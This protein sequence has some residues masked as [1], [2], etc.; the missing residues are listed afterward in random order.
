M[1]SVKEETSPQ[2]KAPPVK[3][4]AKKSRI[5]AHVANIGR[6]MI[7]ELRSIRSDP[8]M[9]ILVVYAFSIAI[10]TVANGASTEAT[11]LAV[12]IVDE[13]HSALSRKI[14]DGLTPPLF[15]R[16]VEI[17]PSDIDPSMD[18]NRFVFVIEIPPDFQADVLA[19]R[20]TSV[21][22]NADAT[23]ITQAGNGAGYIQTII[24]NEVA[25]SLTGREAGYP[26]PVNAVVRV[27]FNPNLHSS[28]FTSVMQVINN[29][30]MLTVILSGAAL[31][32][33]REQG[34]VEHLLVMPVVPAEI[35]L[36]KMLANG[37]VTLVAA[38]LSL[39]FVVEW[40]LKVPIVG[41]IALFIGGSFF[42]VFTVAA[43]GILL[44]TIAASMGQF[45]LLVIPVLLV[46]MLLS[47]SMTPMES[48]PDWLQYI[49]QIISPTPHFVAFAQGV[50]YRG[51]GLSIVWPQLIAIIIIGSVYF[52]FALRR[53]RRVIFGA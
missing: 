43:L 19:G 9:L 37:L 33:E 46:M 16:A 47:G 29:V 11:N 21:Q 8:V 45:G 32:R 35:M 2:S 40:W 49:M 38:A 18:S 6:L 20:Q 48:M 28:W 52:G 31:I 34:T 36:A 53:F 14:A 5:G 30:T 50:L 41:S 12:G 4:R 22:I 25:A 26:V 17:A 51:A 3:G 15:R 27:K 13:D 7:K 39:V 24:M 23:A 10:Y 44:G 1:A 42:Y